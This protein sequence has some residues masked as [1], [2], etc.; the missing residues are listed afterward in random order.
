MVKNEGGELRPSAEWVLYFTL[1]GLV[2]ITEAMG[3][4]LKI[5]NWRLTPSDLYIRKIAMVTLWRGRL[6][7]IA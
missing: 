2:F 3:E 6:E 1:R 4:S 5:L 7:S